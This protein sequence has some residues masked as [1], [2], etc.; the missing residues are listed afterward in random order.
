MSST[1]VLGK[2]PAALEERAGVEAA[3]LVTSASRGACAHERGASENG[4]RPK[5]GGGEVQEGLG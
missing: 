3:V 2:R 1:G 5:R 4:H